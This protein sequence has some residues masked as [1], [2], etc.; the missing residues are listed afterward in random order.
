MGEVGAGDTL[1]MSDIYLELGHANEKIGS[2]TQ[3]EPYYKKGALIRERQLGVRH[4]R[5]AYIWFSLG[6]CQNSVGNVVES[7]RNLEAALQ[8]LEERV[9]RET[10]VVGLEAL[11]RE[12]KHI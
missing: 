5:T 10:D 1:H 6:R 7:K 11:K 9:A 8:I 2:W 12:I 3:A 4:I